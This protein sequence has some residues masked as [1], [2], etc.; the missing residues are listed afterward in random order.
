MIFDPIINTIKDGLGSGIVTLLKFGAILPVPIVAM[1]VANKFHDK[2]KFITVL[3]AILA[4]CVII[5]FAK[6]Y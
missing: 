4:V 5:A 6:F 3:C 2:S 1:V